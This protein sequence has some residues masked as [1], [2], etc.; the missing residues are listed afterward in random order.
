M[1]KRK[2]RGKTAQGEGPSSSEPEIIIHSLS[3][4]EL[5]HIKKDFSH[6]EGESLTT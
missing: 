3:L 4:E 2:C 5:P 6:L 1:A